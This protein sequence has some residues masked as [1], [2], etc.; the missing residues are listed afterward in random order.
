MKW[1]IHSDHMITGIDVVFI[2]AKNSQKLGEWYKEM[3]EIDTVFQT[4]DFSWQEFSFPKEQLVT[5]FAID[6]GG[7]DKSEVERQ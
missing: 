2:H 7:Q 1:Q 3:L 6:S 5:R 4:P